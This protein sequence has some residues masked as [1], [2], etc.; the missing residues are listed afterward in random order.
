MANQSTIPD[1]SLTLPGEVV[2]KLYPAMRWA[3]DNPVHSSLLP[4]AY[5]FGWCGNEMLKTALHYEFQNMLN[6]KG[7]GTVI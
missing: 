7:S 3:V 1:F 6:G 4:L 5:L 2:A